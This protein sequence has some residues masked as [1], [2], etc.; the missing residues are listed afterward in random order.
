MM[1]PQVF[2]WD[3]GFGQPFVPPV[4]HVPS[5]Q[6]Q[7]GFT[8]A[9]SGTAIQDTPAGQAMAHIEAGEW[10]KAIQAI[11]SLSE[12]DSN[13]VLDERGVLRPLSAMKSA[14][15]ASMPEE[16]RRTF[17]RLNDPAANTRLAEALQTTELQERA[18]AFKSIVDS[19]ALCDAAASAAEQLGDIRFEQGRFN[20]AAAYYR[21][22]ADHPASTADDPGL[23]ARRLTALSR[24]EQWMA[25]D[26]LAEYARFRHP[27]ASIQVAGQDTPIQSFIT[28]LAAS[29]DA[30]PKQPQNT[31]PLRLTLPK[32]MYLEYDRDL[33]AKDHLSL[34]RLVAQNHNLNSIIDQAI[35]PTIAADDDRLFTLALGSIARVDPQTGTELWRVGDDNETVQKLQQR[36]HYVTSG[37]NSS[38]VLQEDTLL[39]TLPGEDSN[40]SVYLHAINA[41][42]GETRWNVYDML[43]SNSESVVGE[44][45]VVDDRVYFITYRSSMD[46]TLRVV[47]LADGSELSKLSLGKVSKG[48]NLNSP[49]ELSPR[50]TMG[51]GHLMVQTN[52]GALIAVDVNKMAIAWA[53]SQKIRQSGMNMMR[54]RGFYVADAMCKHTG[55]VIAEDGMVVAKDTRTNRVVALREYDAAMVWSADCDADATIVHHD[56]D[57]IYILGSELVALD[58][59]TGERIWWTEHQGD[60]SG[61]PVF[62]DDACLIQGDRRLCRIDLR[63]GRLTHDP[64]DVFEAAALKVVGNRLIRL[65]DQGITAIRLP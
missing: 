56:K 31:T 49:A 64:K 11:E 43:R 7:D 28:E 8:V 48:P 24:A 3:R 25:F 21:F 52:N 22:A 19:Y 4:Q 65:S 2:G 44:P 27:E 32:D 46:L 18:S 53:F 42:T 54:R 61:T 38:L 37:L 29:R 16:G 12:T 6:T 60:T 47:R 17:C 23:M 63:T 35:A 5:E 50:L 33:I 9:A 20:E 58:R 1:G 40:L 13:L 14:M 30:A 55:N 36:M 26:Q 62:T 15:I 59:R 10:V 57:R 51:Q 39:A 34:L 45:L 41:K